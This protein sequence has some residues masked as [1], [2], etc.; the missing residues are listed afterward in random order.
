MTDRKERDA[1]WS[2]IHTAEDAGLDARKPEHKDCAVLLE[3]EDGPELK[4][5]LGKPTGSADAG[6]ARQQDQ[7]VVLLPQ[8]DD[9]VEA[10]SL[11]R[12]FQLV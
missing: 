6:L 9:S 8:Q 12:Y 4:V 5:D 11:D 3:V 10:I 1:I 2:F 7:S